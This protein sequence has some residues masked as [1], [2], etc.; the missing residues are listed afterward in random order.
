MLQQ[1][2]GQLAPMLSAAAAA[3]SAA[4]SLST[5]AGSASG[6]RLQ[7]AGEQARSADRLQAL[8]ARFQGLR[9]SRIA[10]REWLAVER[11]SR[12]TNSDPASSGTSGAS[13]SQR[14][15]RQEDG[16]H[17][18]AP[19]LL[20]EG[21]PSEQTLR[22]EELP[23]LLLVLQGD[24]AGNM[25]LW[26]ESYVIIEV[27]WAQKCSKN[28]LNCFLT[29]LSCCLFGSVV[30]FPLLSGRGQGSVDWCALSL[31][32]QACPPAAHSHP[33]Y[34]LPCPR[35]PPGAGG[36]PATCR[37][38]GHGCR[39]AL[40]AQGCTRLRA[41]PHLWHPHH[42]CARRRPSPSGASSGRGTAG[43]CRR[44]CQAP[45]APGRERQHRWRGVPL[46]RPAG[47]AGAAACGLVC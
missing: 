29:G 30:C 39:H 42:P 23:P 26:Q 28:A 34:C 7:E 1:L 17:E 14:R 12:S 46:P 31:I 20:L 21:A 13:G 24:D 37:G 11:A 4:A 18:A 27:G 3:S 6:R 41:G 33:H 43:G 22:G 19:P 16:A 9:D 25:P 15:L 36:E 38:P 45:A 32:R 8:S 10:L 44:R 40:P 47:W 2:S 5:A 35:F